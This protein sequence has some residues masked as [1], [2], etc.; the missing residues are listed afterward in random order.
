MLDPAEMAFCPR[1]GQRLVDR[2]VFHQTRRAC[3]KCDF[4]YFRDPKVAVAVCVVRGNEVLL[5][6]R[7]VEPERGKWALPAGYVDYGEDP[8]QAATREVWEETGLVVTLNG[9]VDVLPGDIPD[10]GASIVIVYAGQVTGGT[11]AADDDVDAA[12]YFPMDDL[13][14]MAFANTRLAIQ[15]AREL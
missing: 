3:D 7:A 4:V 14:E 6:R 15:R 8:R 11:L 12:G 5:V 2:E 1:C 13:P 10:R 9:L